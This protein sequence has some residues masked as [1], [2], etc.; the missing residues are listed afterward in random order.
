MSDRPLRIAC[1]GR[2]G[3]TAQAL[4]SVA[5]RDSGLDLVAG[6]RETLDLKD[7]ASLARFL[8][9]A[10]PDAVINTAAYNAVD[11]AE[12]EPD[13]AMRI[14]AD[15]PAALARLCRQRG[16]SLIHMSTDC[17]FDGAKTGLYTEED[18]PHPLSVYGCSKLAGEQA[19]LA[20]DAAALVMRVCWVFSE[21]ADSFVSRMIELA[22]TRPELRVVSDQIG[23]PTYAP[24]IAAALIA[25]ARARREDPARLSGLLHVA[26]PD[27]MARD[28]MARAIM[29]ESKAQ[30]GPVAAIA[31]VLTSDFASA[32]ARPLNA[33]LSGVR[34]T[35][36]L[37]L[38]FTS[39]P[40]ALTRSVRGVLARDAGRG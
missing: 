19:V 35:K 28:A 20:E 6:G 26:S 14:N 24:D 13:E 34:A 27:M 17:V 11:R 23:P 2:A 9:A 7:H 38:G 16:L 33:R 31:S 29:A 10:K 15:G 8:D 12:S 4:A 22:R 3:Q 40:E 25:A 18:A 36:R 39:F 37:G 1:I 30:D 32:A 21:F 5:A